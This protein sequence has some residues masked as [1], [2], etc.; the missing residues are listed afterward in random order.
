MTGDDHHAD[1]QTTHERNERQEAQ[2]RREC[3][4]LMNENRARFQARVAGM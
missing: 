2:L 3:R 4:D 1:D